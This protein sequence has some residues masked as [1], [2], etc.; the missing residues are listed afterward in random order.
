[1]NA[2]P[3][4]HYRTALLLAAVSLLCYV[5]IYAYYLLRP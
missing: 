2:P 1:M 5:G 3:P 4:A